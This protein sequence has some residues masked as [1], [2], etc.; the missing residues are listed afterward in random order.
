M[1]LAVGTFEG[2]V[3]AEHAVVGTHGHLPAQHLFGLVIAHG[4]NR[5]AAADPVTDLDGLFHG[6]VVPLVD[7]VDQVVLLDVVPSLLISISFSA[8]SGTLFTQTSISMFPPNL[9]VSY[10]LQIFEFA[11]TY[12]WRIAAPAHK[13]LLS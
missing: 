11:S 1:P 4:D 12:K 5:D 7:R 13:T 2:V 8:V 6:I 9:S 10:E 3:G